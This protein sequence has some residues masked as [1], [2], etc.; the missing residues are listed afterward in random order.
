MKMNLFHTF[1]FTF[2]S[3]LSLVS[4][5][6]NNPHR[7]KSN[8]NIETIHAKIQSG[9]AK[10][11]EIVDYFLERAYAYNKNLNAIISY[12]PTARLDA[13]YLDEYYENNTRQRRPGFIGKLHCVPTI[14]KDN[15]DIKG[16]PTTGGIR[17]L[18]YSIPN[19]DATIVKR[20]KAQGVIILGKSNLAELAHGPENSETGGQCH[21]P[22]DYVKSCGASSTGSG[23]SISSA[24]AI[25]S[26][27]TDTDGSI[28]VPG[29]FNGIYGL[30]TRSGE[31]SVEGIIPLMLR[32][33]TVGPFAK[34][35]NDMVLAYS[36][37]QD[38]ASI[39]DEFARKDTDSAPLRVSYLSLFFDSFNATPVS[40]IIDNEVK[41]KAQESLAKMKS[42]KINVSEIVFSQND[43]IQ[44]AQVI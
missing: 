28:L 8:F 1:I 34:H 19:Q 17:P 35:I 18:R 22:F 16:M 30:R 4:C 33:D 6:F 40:Y 9:E 7:S 24:L 42:L 43:L 41:L 39:Y 36:V 38:N 12:N 10:C 27:G 23:A 3:A 20:L 11:S 13:K 25:L 21:N 31:P 29:S 26:V 32:Q 5:L 37:M 44:I 15:I 2:I 14:I